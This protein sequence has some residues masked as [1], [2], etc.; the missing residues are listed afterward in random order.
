MTG[1]DK[2]R[3]RLHQNTVRF[4][5]DGLQET[6]SLSISA[7][8]CLPANFVMRLQCFMREWWYKKGVTKN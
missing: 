6:E 1:M 7:I 2:P 3:Y 5:D 8:D 4:Y